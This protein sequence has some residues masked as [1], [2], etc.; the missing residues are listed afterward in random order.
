MSK[1]SAASMMFMDEES[2]TDKTAPEVTPEVKASYG[3]SV[4]LPS[5]GKLGYPDT[6]TYRDMMVRDEEILASTTGDT[7]SSVLNGVIKSVLNDCEFFEKMS[8]HDR[9]FLLVWLWANNYD[10]I[11]TMSVTCPKC[12]T[13]TNHKVDLTKL[14]TT[15]INMDIKNPFELTLKNG[16]TVKVRLITVGDEL[17]VERYIRINDDESGTLR[18]TYELLTIVAALDL[19]MEMPFDS[20]VQW[21]R[22]NITSKEMGIIKAYHRFFRFGVE[23]DKEYKCSACGEVTVAPIPFQAEDI[24]YPTVSADFESFL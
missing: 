2:S 21:V 13:V 16:N 6:V 12:K 9:D 17:T 1:K 19:G 20:K 10:A 22:E 7:Y 5:K 23:P 24:L 14:K 18:K 11:K 15:D 8:I 4:E 3:M